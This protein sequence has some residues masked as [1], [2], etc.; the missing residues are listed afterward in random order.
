MH[1]EKV[2]ASK[3]LT[4]FYFDDQQAIKEGA[5]ENGFAYDGQPLTRVH[6]CPAAGRIA[7][8]YI[9]FI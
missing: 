4:G 3:G 1:I 7:E 5:K 9:Y 2:L 8:H 6:R